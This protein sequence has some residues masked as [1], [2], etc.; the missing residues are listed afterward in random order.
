MENY[1]LFNYI[2]NN[3]SIDEK[4]FDAL[5]F[6]LEQNIYYYGNQFK[7]P[8]EKLKKFKTNYIKLLVKL[9]RVLMNNSFKKKIQSNKIIF[10]NAYFSV[11][12][13]LK[14]IG[15]NVCSP[16]WLLEFNKEYAADYHLYKKILNISKSFSDKS[17]SELLEEKFLNDINDFKHELKS[18]Y[19]NS[20][21]R[22]IVVPNDVS[23]Y[24]NISLQIFKELQKPSFIFLHGLPGRYNS[25]DENRSDYLLV[26]GEKIKDNYIKAGINKNKIFVTGHPYYQ[27]CVQK[28]LKFGFDT[29]LIITKAMNGAQHS[30]GVRLS[31]RGNLIVYLLS[32]QIA[33]KKLNVTSVRLRP[34]PSE[35]PEWYY[36]FIDKN[37]FIFDSDTLHVS[38]N[39]S[40]LVIGPSST[41]FLES[42]YRG[43]NYLVYEPVKENL[44]LMNYT[45]VPPFDGSDSRVPLARNEEELFY[46]LKNRIITDSTIFNDYIQTPFNMH[47]IK[48][49]IN[50]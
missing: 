40:S 32:I 10:S 5:K 31:D 23:F 47:F 28:E 49:L 7:Y 37:F 34:H 33:L 3:S 26:W 29:I 22:S 1:Y 13:E 17:F 24:E 25:I 43:I 38:L 30:D 46:F 9:F 4:I 6:E 50:I 2:K 42:I 15:F 27:N 18:F 48:S 44:D 14:K 35:N 41:V 8:K 36:Q 20:N 12:E 16:P 11:N 39:K 45:L 21:A 19:L